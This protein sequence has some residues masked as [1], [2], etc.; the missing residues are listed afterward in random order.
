MAR[1]WVRVLRQPLNKRIDEAV[2]DDVATDQRE[3]IF[4]QKDDLVATSVSSTPEDEGVAAMPSARPLAE[5]STWGS[6]PSLHALAHIA[7]DP[8]YTLPATAVPTLP[9]NSLFGSLQDPY[10]NMPF[11]DP[12]QPPLDVLSFM[13]GV[14]QW[15]WPR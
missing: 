9:D 1:Q 7:T 14:D 5:A 15:N 11:G 6:A 12:T 10:T 13:D 3:G 8:G 4:R 2:Q